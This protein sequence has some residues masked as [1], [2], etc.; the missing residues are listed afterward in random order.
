M[1]TLHF[2]S[3]C[4][5]SGYLKQWGVTEEKSIFPYQYYSSVE[6]LEASTCFPPK[7]AFYSELTEKDVSDED[8]NTAKNEYDTKSCLPGNL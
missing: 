6:E 4:N 7:H 5:Y 1:D 3:P 8:Y 2:T